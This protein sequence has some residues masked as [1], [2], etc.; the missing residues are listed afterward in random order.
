MGNFLEVL[1]N[2]D[3]LFLNFSGQFFPRSLHED[4]ALHVLTWHLHM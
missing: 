3:W 2:F 1:M 4:I